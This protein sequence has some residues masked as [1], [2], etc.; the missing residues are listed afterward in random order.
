MNCGEIRVLLEEYIFG[1]LEG[2][3]RIEVEAHLSDC[4]SCKGE[5]EELKN[6]ISG[7]RT[8]Y[9]NVNVPEKLDK[10]NVI[11]KNKLAGWFS[12]KKI[13]ALAACIVTV[14]VVTLLS[15]M[16]FFPAYK[17]NA[18][19]YRS[20]YSITPQS[21]DSTGVN[22][23]S[24]YILKSKKK[25]VLDEL[26]KNISIDGEP[27][28]AI[29]R[30]DSNTFIITPSREFDQ[31]KLYTFRIKTENGN[32]IIW[33]FQIRAVFKVV[34]VF[35]AD[36]TT[37][38]P[39]NTGIEIYLSHEDFEDIDN[40][41]EISPAVKGS[42]ERH[43]SAAVFVPEK[44]QEGTLYT[45][46]LKRGL[47]LKDTIYSL[48]Q[49]YVFQFETGV[50]EEKPMYEKGGFSYNKV[51]N[52]YS[53]S[54][55]P[56]IP[57]NY[58]VNQDKYK[59]KIKI[60]TTVYAYNDVE[61]FISA[62]SKRQSIPYWA[63]RSLSENI[64]PVKGLNSVAQFEQE[65]P[66]IPD[67]EQF[68]KIPGTLPEGF[69]IADSRWEDIN[70]QTFIE[71]TNI[72][73][74]IMK[75]SNKTLMWLNDLKTKQPIT[76][77]V[78]SL[79]GEYSPYY[80]DS[81][82]VV[83]FDS[84]A[85]ESY[86]EPGEGLPQQKYLKI[87]TGDNKTAILDY[88]S[89]MSGYGD[90]TGAGTGIYWDLLQLDRNLYKP[91][92]VVNFWGLVK[93]RYS[94]EN[95]NELT[96]EISQGYR[97]Y[98]RYKS[99]D[100]QTDF[101]AAHYS[102]VYDQPLAGET[103]AV[104]NGIF[105]GSIR[106]PMLDPGGYQLILK[107]GRRIIANSYISIENYVK[108]SYKLEITS[109]KEA[110][111]PGQPVNFTVKA[112]FFEDT[113]VP[114]LNVNYDIAGYNLGGNQVSASGKTDLQGSI[115][116]KYVPDAGSNVQ[117]E[118]YVGINCHAVFPEA[119]ETFGNNGVRVFVNDV[120]VK[121]NANTKDNK[122]IINAQLN[123]IVLDR[124]N[125]GT[126][127]D[128]EDYLGEPAAGKELKAT[129]YRNT[130]I[131]IED[132]EYYDFINKVTQRKYRYEPHKEAVKTFSMKTD[133]KGR[134]SYEFDTPELE[135]GYYT[136]D[137]RCTDS[138][139]RNMKFEVYIGN[140][141]GGYN[142]DDN[143]Y[144]LDGGKESY[145]AG[146][147]V[148]L[149]FKKGSKSMPE[150]K[151]LFI[152]MQNGIREYSIKDGP[153]Y[154]FDFAQKDIPNVHVTGV[155]FNG[156]TYVESEQFNAVYD[157]QEKNL[158]L[159]AK[160]DKQAYRP[161]DEVTFDIKAKDKS[162]APKKAVVNVSLVDEALFKLYSQDIDTL[163]ALYSGV[164]SGI[165]FSY[166]SHVNSGR[167]M[168]AGAVQA[169][170]GEEKNKGNMKNENDRPDLE[171]H[172][173]TFGGD[174]KLNALSI[175]GFDADQVNVR[176]DF[177]DAA[178][179]ANVTLDDNGHGTL[180]FK[181]PDNITSWRVTLSGVS[182]DLSAGS[183]KVGLNVTLPFFIN[184]TLNSTYL[185]GDKPVLGANAYGNNLKKGEDVTFEVTSLTDPDRIER[186]RGKAFE[187]VNIP[188]WEMKEGSEDI[189]I[190][191][192]STSGLEDSVKQTIKTVRTYHQAEKAVYYDLKP[193]IKIDG[194]DT[195]NTKLVFSDRSRGE[196]L[197]ELISL[198]YTR[199][200]R[201]DQ[202][203][204]A[205]IASGLIDKYFKQSSAYLDDPSFKLTDYQ[206]QDGGIAL[207]PYGS[208]D[209]DISSRLS[210]LVK[211]SVNTQKLKEYFYGVLL[212]DSP[213]LK[214][215]ALY[216]L[217]VL[218][219]PVLLSLDKASK[220][221]NAGL[222]DLLYMALAYCELGESQKAESIFN[223]KISSYIEEYKPFYRI[224]TGK[225]SDD[226]LEC[227]SLAAVL[228]SK[229]D[230]PEKRGL[231]EYCIKNSTKD[232]LI[233]IEKLLYITCE[234]EK[235]KDGAVKFSY[236]Y[237]GEKK[238]R[239][240]KNGETYTITIP[241]ENLSGFKVDGT[242]GDISL[243]SVFSTGIDSL[244]KPDADLKVKR[245][246]SLKGNKTNNF[247]QGDIVRVEIKWDI[248]SRA[249]DGEYEVTDYLPSGLKPI[250][251]PY[252]AGINPADGSTPFKRID[253]Q[254]V[255][256]YVNK[257]W[258]NKKPLVYY[259]RIVS[260]GIYK[261]EGTVIQSVASRT[262]INMDKQD[263]VTIE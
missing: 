234:I 8:A 121:L 55:K 238:S 91:D 12:H 199:G 33:T 67:G 160:T 141:S 105:K 157:Y 79:V 215:N 168:T 226:I 207:L 58:F 144:Y 229:L 74:Y 172:Q 202:K 161:G 205:Q 142:Y 112:S 131:K 155:Y 9:S 78:V 244:N 3:I 30:E 77:A 164:P 208:S 132:G 185:S 148:D 122:G 182:D 50:K 19:D 31:N 250:E 184:Y 73:M 235:S 49:D 128:S 214:G 237:N 138:S 249:V 134:A 173:T 42:F 212:D 93:D 146:E 41:F 45:V 206:T 176:Q 222:K 192:Q 203:L 251:N 188:L 72:G 56:Y 153:G 223:E 16:N 110:V 245:E 252:N 125:D 119:G 135:E 240:L 218:R 118:Q 236:S 37:N 14:L 248:D 109:D 6:S 217:A 230:K 196:F 97:Y 70:F 11:Q 81:R 174:L 111:F 187:R 106:L 44:L 219:E 40:Y 211:D 66:G 198:L 86:N 242:E 4:E 59:G 170:M 189:V 20:G 227:T 169:V 52:E 89:G 15:A 32:D 263:I 181:L 183:G 75:G 154:S 85:Q 63:Y 165:E 22:P 221:E 82:G 114:D 28:P 25:I 43:N 224:K 213:G 133:S 38:V 100:G 13:A 117:G 88:Y 258:E 256:F 34:S 180:K 254:K 243:V 261:A 62:A 64:V 57:F 190:K 46:R 124:L 150:G 108:P 216:G 204:S 253:G 83:Y 36:K 80:S 255:T 225:D 84:I 90:D 104:E 60:S 54:E 98:G 10:I 179:F 194:G 17:V 5:Y 26:K 166:E 139:G 178:Y 39:T 87:T 220:V 209:P 51:L 167:E 210:S 53:P 1:E 48:N 94:D 239:T 96:V 107:K 140:D 47:K 127:K 201:V 137:V 147:A 152:K 233:N 136:A 103:I 186:I 232:I 29:A 2:N 102:P 27:E 113:G 115:A 21:Y 156:L 231:Y 175:K 158:V 163:A 123:K 18:G 7:I 68:I 76:D 171:R 143:R 99:I 24:K 71:V 193:G 262:A 162:G 116:V 35:P 228:A 191:A 259:A 159:E 61:A 195:G 246:Y 200:N 151:Y 177:R 145:N 126:E 69:Y 197:P 257:A 247:K 260:A 149:T 129:V 120:N 101:K 92:D 65:L 241:S 130:W 95:I 23:D